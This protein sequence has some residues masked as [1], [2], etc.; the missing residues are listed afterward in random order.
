[1]TPLRVTRRYVQGIIGAA[2]AQGLVD[3]VEQAL[4]SIDTVIMGNR[5]FRNLLFHPMISRDRK[6]NL[7]HKIIGDHAPA[8]VKNFID[9]V[10]EKKRE[11]ILASV[12]GEFKAAADDLRGIMRARVTAASQPTQ[13]QVDRLKAQLERTLNKKVLIEI[14][15]DKALLGGMQIMIGTYILDGSISGQLGRLYK[16]LQEE[17]SNIK[18]VA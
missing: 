6:K 7:L 10:V 2:Q 3:A 9:L 16:H 11:H 12:Y 5:D 18:S 4:Q 13:A 15:V 1:V 8:V 17:V 14:Q